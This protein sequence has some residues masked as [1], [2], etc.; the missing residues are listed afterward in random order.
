MKKKISYIILSSV[1]IFIFIVFF[2][3]MYKN[4]I[5]KPLEIKNKKLAEFSSKDLYFNKEININE[6]VSNKNFTIINIW[7]SWCIPCKLEHQNL[8]KLSKI[9]DLTIVGLNYK[10][11][12]KNAKKFISDLG[13]PFYEILT[14][15]DGTISIQL[16]AYGVPETFLINRE[17][18]ILKKYIGQL[19]FEQILEI[20]K[21]IN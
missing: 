3:G 18:E 7:A 11:K 9:E 19:T 1:F 16:G 13:N 14:D 6:L 8:M 2:K 12:T 5:Y 15:P 17:S 10:D 4:N 20:K 21:I